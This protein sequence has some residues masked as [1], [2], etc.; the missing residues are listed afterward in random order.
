MINPLV[1]ELTGGGIP[2]IQSFFANPNNV[3]TIFAN[4]RMRRM[5]MKGFRFGSS[6]EILILINN[7]NINTNNLLINDG[8]EDIF[9]IYE[10]QDS[11]RL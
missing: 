11:C 2:P 10:E 3:K 5:K 8:D 6:L 7:N 1:K 9:N 4:W